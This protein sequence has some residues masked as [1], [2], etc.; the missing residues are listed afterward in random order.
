[1]Q[2]QSGAQHDK[3]SLTNPVQTCRWH[4]S[5]QRALKAAGLALTVVRL[6]YIRHVFF[7]K[8]LVEFELTL[9][10]IKLG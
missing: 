10:I 4:F 1:M 2:G 8:L 6:R 5:K 9:R 3:S 7:M